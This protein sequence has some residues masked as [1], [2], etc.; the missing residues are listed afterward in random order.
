M[1]VFKDNEPAKSE[2]RKFKIRTIGKPDDFAMLQEVIVRRLKHQEWPLPDLMLIDGGKGQVSAVKKM[3]ARSGREIPVIGLA[4]GPERKRN[5]VIGKIP[6][7][8]DLKTLIRV[9]DEAHRFAIKFHREL[10]GRN[11]LR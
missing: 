8:T 4:K 10:R 7:F 2:Y 5:D 3:V 6:A 11:F 1:V 9:R